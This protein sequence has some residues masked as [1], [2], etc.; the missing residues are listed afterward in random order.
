MNANRNIAVDLED[1]H[2]DIL[3]KSMRGLGIG[4]TEVAER[5]RVEK[6][7]IESVLLGGT[8]GEAVSGMAKVLNLDAEKLLVASNK[9]WAPKSDRIDCL[10]QFN[11]P[12]GSM[13]VNAYLVWCKESAKAWVFD[14]GPEAA[15]ILEFLEKENLSVDAIF[16]THTHGDHI[17]CLEKLKQKT[18]NPPVFVHKLEAIGGVN[19]IDEGFER[20]IGSLSLRS[21]HTHGHSVGGTTYLIDGLEMPVAIVGDALFA[22]SMGGGMVS[23]QDALQCNREKIM[24]LPEKT[25]VC[26]GHG[27]MTTIEEERRHNPFFPE[28]PGS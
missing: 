16:L 12:F 10:E 18:H 7:R 14:T 1:N 19:L 2:E 15:P 21:L 3:A 4:K 6:S 24:T 22:G 27:P 8:D 23:Y 11:L 17:A 26:P 20:E 13:L 28:S 9:A 5:I 25:I